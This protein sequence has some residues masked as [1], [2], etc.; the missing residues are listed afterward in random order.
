MK[1][2]LFAVASFAAFLAFSERCLAHKVNVF[3]FVDGDAIQ[4]ECAFSRS[5]KVRNGKL[6]VTDLETGET[7]F[8]GTT[9]EQGLFRFRPPDEFLAAGHG[10]NIRL[11]AGEG[12]QDDWKISPEELRALSRT[13]RPAAEPRRVSTAS[14]KTRVPPLAA[15]DVD[16][17]E[18][19]IGRVVDEKLAPVKQALARQRDDEPGLRDIVGGI[20]WILGLLGLGTYMKYRRSGTP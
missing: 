2:H 16:E 1:R 5:Q 19:A 10:L 8:E 6:V 17:L 12:H 18:A 3:A 11:Y 20:G 4:I 7:I 15:I 14:G 9:D 13:A